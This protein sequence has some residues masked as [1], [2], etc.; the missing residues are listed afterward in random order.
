MYKNGKWTIGQFIGHISNTPE[1]PLVYGIVYLLR[2]LFFK[3]IFTKSHTFAP[4]LFT[5]LESVIRQI[6][7]YEIEMEQLGNLQAI[8]TRLMPRHKDGSD[9]GPNYLD[10]ELKKVLLPPPP[11][12]FCRHILSGRKFQAAS[13]KRCLHSVLRGV[14]LWQPVS[15]VTVTN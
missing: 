1:I 9:L 4:I 12:E 5:R 8:W 3:C 13:F 11:R 15:Y 14:S 7:T 6:P 10:F 2:V